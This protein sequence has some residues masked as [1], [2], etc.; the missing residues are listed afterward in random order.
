MPNKVMLYLSKNYFN[1]FVHVKFQK[2][3]AEK[4]GSVNE[5]AYSMY[6][7]VGEISAKTIRV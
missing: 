6:V 4:E 7:C 3:S 2:K 5:Y 1:E